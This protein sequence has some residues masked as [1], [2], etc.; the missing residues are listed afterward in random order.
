MLPR[1]AHATVKTHSL[2]YHWVFIDYLWFSFMCYWLSLIFIFVLIVLDV[3]WLCDDLLWFSLICHWFPSIIHWLFVLWNSLCFPWFFMD[4]LWY[5]S[6]LFDFHRV[7]LIVFDFQWLFI[8]LLWCS[9]IFD[10]FSLIFIF[11]MHA[12]LIECC[13]LNVSSENKTYNVLLKFKV[14]LIHIHIKVSYITSCE[15]SCNVMF[16]A[17][18]FGNIY[19][20]LLDMSVCILAMII[21]D[22]CL[23]MIT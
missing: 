20:S 9:L 5:S 8:N 4:S 6:I 12:F 23:T 16:Y 13:K 17:S 14:W 3:H 2:D 1:G 15:N 18:V 21:H 11:Y 7:L 19:Q 22:V 10:R